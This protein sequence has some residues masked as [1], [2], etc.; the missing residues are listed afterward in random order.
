MGIQQ[1]NPKPKTNSETLATLRKKRFNYVSNEF[2]NVQ[3]N[4]KL[5]LTLVANSSETSWTAKHSIRST[6]ISFLSHPLL[7]FIVKIRI[8]QF[9]FDGVID[10]FVVRNCLQSKETQEARLI[11]SMYTNKFFFYSSDSLLNKSSA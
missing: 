7:I 9:W 5:P 3:R 8:I 4:G 6:T 10:L 1:V 11:K 2:I